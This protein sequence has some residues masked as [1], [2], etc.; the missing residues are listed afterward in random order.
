MTGEHTPAKPGDQENLRPVN[1]CTPAELSVFTTQT[2]QYWIAKCWA[3]GW[4]GDLI[5]VLDGEKA[6]Q[7]I[8][9]NQATAHLKSSESGMSGDPFTD[10]Q[11]IHSYTMQDAIDDGSLTSLGELAR[12]AGFTIPVWVTDGVWSILNPTDEL[13]AQGQDF[14]GRAWDMLNILNFSIKLAK[15]KTGQTLYFSP[16]FIV[17]PGKKAKQLELLCDVTFDGE[18]KPNLTIYQEREN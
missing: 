17:T 8:A 9:A 12:E 10:A 3:C 5:P 16:Y 6:Q 1:P 15:A 2:D 18:G 7:E 4:T 11:I 14:N 13:K